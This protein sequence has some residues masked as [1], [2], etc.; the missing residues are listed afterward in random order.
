[1]PIFVK[2]QSGSSMAAGFLE[3]DICYNYIMWDSMSSSFPTGHM[4]KVSTLEQ[5]K[6][7]WVLN[8]MCPMKTILPFYSL[9]PSNSSLFSVRRA[10]HLGDSHQL[11]G[12]LTLSSFPQTHSYTMAGG[13][14]EE[15][16]GRENTSNIL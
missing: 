4:M 13:A 15:G 8:N 16:G 5:G 10:N 2:N 9:T 3:L 7:L 12:S 1:M 11:G 14:A 6:S